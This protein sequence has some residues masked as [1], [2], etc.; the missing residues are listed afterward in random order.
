VQT[1]EEYYKYLDFLWFINICNEVILK[2]YFKQ[3]FNLTEE[4]ANQLLASWK[5]SKE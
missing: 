2:D 1:Q 4:E 3:K 5:K